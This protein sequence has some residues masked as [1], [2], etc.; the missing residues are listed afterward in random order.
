MAVCARHIVSWL[1]R[2][3]S[4]LLCQ[5]QQLP[6][7]LYLLFPQLLSAAAHGS[8]LSALGC[9][10]CLFFDSCDTYLLLAA[11]TCAMDEYQLVPK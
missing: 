1:A 4:P 10:K 8:P 7:K 9:C 5:L 2:P 11:A 6:P 3:E